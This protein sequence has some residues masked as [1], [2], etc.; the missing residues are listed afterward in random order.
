[1]KLATFRRTPEG[2]NEIGVV[3]D[4]GVVAVLAPEADAAFTSML[5][6]IDAGAA[7]LERARAAVAQAEQVP[8]DGL[9]LLAP[10][11]E[12][13]QMRDS[14]CFEKHLRQGRANRYVFGLD[15][16]W[17]DPAEVELPAVWYEQPIYYKSNRFSVAGPETEIRWPKGET[18]LDFELEMAMVLGRKGRDI[19]E[20]DAEDHIFGFTI[21]NDFSA[22]DHQFRESLGGLGPAKGKDFDTGN[23]LGPWIVTM[24][25]IGNYQDL[26]MRARVNGETMADGRSSEMHHSFRRVLAHIS[27]DE[28]VHAGEVIGS[29]TLG[30][31]CGLEHNRF[32]QPGD[33]VEL[34]IDGIGVLRNTIGPRR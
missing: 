14:L 30:D 17:V 34:E 1:M 22:R 6:L 3:Q 29:G 21:F 16:G 20:E 8:L 23:V 26:G 9:R 5:A 18:R 12:P 2:G 15:K 7:G 10:L 25:E 13:R 4:D 11:P 28:T 33:V 32:L 31:G 24:D 19:A 27:R